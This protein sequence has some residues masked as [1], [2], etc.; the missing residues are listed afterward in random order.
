MNNQSISNTGI[1]AEWV[2]L[3]RQYCQQLVTPEIQRNVKF[4]NLKKIENA[5]RSGEFITNGEPIILCENG[6]L[7]DGQHRIR[8]F[9]RTGIFPEALIVS[10]VILESAY[11][12]FDSGASRSMADSFKA[13][14]IKNYTKSA[15]STFLLM[16]LESRCIGN[17]AVHNRSVIDFYYENQ[18]ALDYWIGRDRDID[19]VIKGSVRTGCYVYLEKAFGRDLVNNLSE[20]L[21]SGI[22]N[23]TFRALRGLLIRNSNRTRGKMNR[24]DLAHA[25][26]VAAS[27]HAG[28]RSRKRIVFKD[29]FPYLNISEGGAK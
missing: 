6:T 25:L 1:T 12:T 10:G 22:G 3:T 13:A 16:E 9:M 7:I 15:S 11:P 24:S 2:Q 5:L 28:G 20:T 18:A 21:K 19:S 14:G 26:I 4:R 23:A 29:A 8:A 27:A 17:L